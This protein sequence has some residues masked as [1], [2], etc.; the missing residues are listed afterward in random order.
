MPNL[1]NEQLYEQKFR[2][3]DT[4]NAIEV[5]SYILLMGTTFFGENYFTQLNIIT[6]Y[7]HSCLY[8]LEKLL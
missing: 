8:I 7:F 2:K 5:V 3:P 6:L 1:Y 4:A